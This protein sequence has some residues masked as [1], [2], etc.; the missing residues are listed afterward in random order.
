M[1]A[2]R[3]DWATSGSSAELAAGGMGVVYEA[4]AAPLRRRRVAVKTIKRGPRPVSSAIHARFLR[5]QRNPRET[6]PHAHRPDSRGRAGGRTPVLCD[7]VHCRGDL[8]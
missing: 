7:A 2:R 3:L 6:A 5:E 1:K 4:I 8:R